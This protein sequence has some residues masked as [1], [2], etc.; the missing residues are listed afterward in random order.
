[1]SLNVA[2]R[3]LNTNQSILQ[4]IGHNISNANTVGYSKQ[5]VSLEAVAGQKLG[6]GYI[7][8]G[9][10]I[11]GIRRSYD[12]FLTRQ[13]NS[14]QTVA[15]ADEARFNKMK[16]VEALFPLGAGSLGA[17]LNGALNAWV[18][19]QS[20]P[21]DATARQVVIDK[22]DQFA[23]RVRDTFSRLDEIGQTARLQAVEA[24]RLINQYAG[25]I[26]DLNDK[27]AR[28]VSFGAPP[29]D[30][31]DQRDRV[32]AD[33]NKLVQVS[34]IAADDGSLSVFVAGSQALVLGGQVASLEVARDPADPDNRQVLNFV[35]DGTRARLDPDFIGGGQL[36]G[37]QQFINNDL[38]QAMGEV[39]RMALA[40]AVEVNLQHQ[41]GLRPDGTRGGRFF[42]YDIPVIP[43]AAPFGLQYQSAGLTADEYVV[44]YTGANV[45]T[46]QRLSDGKYFN[47][48]SGQWSA[49]AT[50]IGF[51]AYTPSSPLVFDGVRLEPTAAGVAGNQ[52]R[53]APGREA[54][55]SLSVGLASPSE[56]A[57][58]SAI[59]V[60]RPT[61]N[62]GSAVIESFG[63][64]LK[65]E[66][67]GFPAPIPTFNLT[68]NA[69]TTSFAIGSV[70]GLGAGALNPPATVAYVPGQPLTV[71]YTHGTP[72]REFTYEVKLRG[73]PANGDVFNVQLVNPG[74]PA[75]RSSAGNAGAILGLRDK[76]VFDGTVKLSD[77][78]VASF[79]GVASTL[80]ESKVNA[81][82]SAAQA[83]QAENQRA[84]LAGVNLD[85]EAALLIQYQQAYQASAKYMGTVQ[86]LFDTLM[87][88]FR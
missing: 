3:A 64:S 45:G 52:Y 37:L 54:A 16:Q 80:N 65:N 70:V 59:T 24:T 10:E 87:S 51:G 86:S 84:N 61:T 82:F 75:A 83:A 7:G 81:T 5:T 43:A 33:L 44:N 76:N 13:A 8:K 26:A 49:T 22:A 15:S 66:S 31:L 48:A 57:S 34:T 56:V 67:G 28:A 77:A 46:V 47:N 17:M 23:A 74:D 85:E 25:Q 30:L 11:A 9:V 41:S 69:A 39:G 78:Y 20:T 29:N 12:A 14:T 79:S 55:R 60:T 72:A 62:T 71:T 53:F 42:N 27:V 40:T 6:N 35:L 68:Y 18:D 21:S 32:L 73:Q 1:M 50:A 19:V 2:A 88:A 58:A 38:N 36:I 63:L 4:V